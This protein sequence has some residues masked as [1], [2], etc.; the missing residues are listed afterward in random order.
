MITASTSGVWKYDEIS[1]LNLR[2]CS[3]DKGYFNA[4]HQLHVH[5]NYPF[6]N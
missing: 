1:I 3:Q 6:M 5:P 2:E 4:M